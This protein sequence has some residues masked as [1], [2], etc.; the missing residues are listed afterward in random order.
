VLFFCSL[1]PLLL[2]ATKDYLSKANE[3]LK[4][5]MEKATNQDQQAT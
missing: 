5:T 1:Y 3:Q 4:E 2:E